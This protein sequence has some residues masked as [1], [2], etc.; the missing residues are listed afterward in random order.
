M[1]GARRKRAHL[2]KVKWP[3][4]GPLLDF[5][6]AV[7]EAQE[8]SKPYFP[9]MTWANLEAFVD[10][11]GVQSDRW[12]IEKAELPFE[13]E[14]THRLFA[15][16]CRLGKVA[17]KYFATHARKIENCLSSGAMEL[18]ELI[19]R[20]GDDRTVQMAAVKLGL[21]ERV[22]SFLVTNTTRP[23]LEL[24][25]DEVM[26]GF[27]PETWRRVC[28]PFCGSLPS[29]NLLDGEPVQRLSLCSRC[30]FQWPVDRL[31]CSICGDKDKEARSYFYSEEVQACRIDI[32]EARQ[33]YIKTIDL[34]EIDVADPCLEDLATH[35][36]DVTAITKGYSRAVP[37]SWLE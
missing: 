31:A 5:Y 30:G 1:Q 16:L 33:R 4:Y 6:I 25:R 29:L 10:G 21:D 37:N 24:A 8:A 19:S 3:A 9:V 15:D 13:T 17:N 18:N 12:L 23:L 22:L 32:C 35:H 36:L 34:R 2:L 7:T 26:V 28:C 20:G 11:G 14:V 27:Q